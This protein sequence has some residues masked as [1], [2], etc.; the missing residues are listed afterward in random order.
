[1]LLRCGD[2]ESL[3]APTPAALEHLAALWGRHAAA[4]AMSS[5]AT[6]VARLIRA[7][8]SL[9]VPL[10]A[11]SLSHSIDSVRC[12]VSQREKFR[13]GANMNIKAFLINT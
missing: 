1:M 10:S 12:S 9:A 7:F 4:E 11:A 13:A 8:H 2:D 3:T 5:A 6:N